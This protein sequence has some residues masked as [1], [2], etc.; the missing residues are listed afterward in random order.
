MDRRDNTVVVVG[1]AG[2]EVVVGRHALLAMNH[3]HAPGVQ[4]VAVG[5]VGQELAP[6]DVDGAKIQ[7][8]EDTV[9][10]VEGAMVEQKRHSAHLQE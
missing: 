8:R 10:L 4:M 9:T 1:D 5:F 7:D 2:Y 3:C 6:A